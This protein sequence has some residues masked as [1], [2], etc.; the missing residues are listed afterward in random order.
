MRCTH[1]T[2]IDFDIFD[3]WVN[4]TFDN[5]QDLIFLPQ[6]SYTDS[7]IHFNSSELTSTT[8]KVSNKY[9]KLINQ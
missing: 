5:A 6:I 8:L 7:N 4:F 2:Q 9:T 3:H 1:L